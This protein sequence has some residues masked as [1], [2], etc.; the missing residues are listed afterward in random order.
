LK[1][2]AQILREG[3]EVEDGRWPHTPSN[4]DAS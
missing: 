2:V 1:A 3:V 4:S